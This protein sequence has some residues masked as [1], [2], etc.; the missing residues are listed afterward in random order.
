MK[1]TAIKILGVGVGS[2]C[3]VNILGKENLMVDV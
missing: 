2:A 1:N 3:K